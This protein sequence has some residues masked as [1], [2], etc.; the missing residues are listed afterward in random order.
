[1][2][3]VWIRSVDMKDL[4]R[5]DSVGHISIWNAGKDAYVGLNLGKDPIVVAERTHDFGAEKFDEQIV[6]GKADVIRTELVQQ[7][8]RWE[9][10][11]SQRNITLD[12][13]DDQWVAYV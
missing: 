3:Q 6:L 7:I 11:A 10:D 1:M 13:V 2:A 5:A 8:H 9:A 4:I 12:H